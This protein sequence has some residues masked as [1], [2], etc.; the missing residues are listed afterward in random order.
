MYKEEGV[1]DEPVIIKPAQSQAKQAKKF[2]G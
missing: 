2:L 1:F